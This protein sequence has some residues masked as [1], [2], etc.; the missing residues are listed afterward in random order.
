M[1]GGVE[2]IAE[3]VGLFALAWIVGSFFGAFWLALLWDRQKP[4]W[5]PK[6]P[7]RPPYFK[8]GRAF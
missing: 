1:R 4:R 3:F 2:D 7:L 5:M 8:H 6:R